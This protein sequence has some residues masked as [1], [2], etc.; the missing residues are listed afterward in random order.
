MSRSPEFTATQVS[1]TYLICLAYEVSDYQVV[2]RPE[3]MDTEYFDVTAHV[4]GNVGLS[5][6]Q[7][8]RPLQEL[9]KERFHLTFRHGTK[10]M[11]GYELVVGAG[12]P[13]LRRSAE[14][15]EHGIGLPGMIRVT[16]APMD[17]VVRGLARQLMVPVKD[18][19]GLKGLYDAILRFD[20]KNKGTARQ[21][22]IFA[23]VEEQLGLK[24]VPAK[25]SVETMMIVHA[26]R[27]PVEN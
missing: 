22:S 18:K 9:L 27:I 14:T 25:V 4:K 2:N 26:G 10:T 11:D 24:L 20:P 12:G 21:P 19:T 6:Q 13:K 17:T 23:A 16:G 3:W 5:Y 15:T 1:L 7:L 8:Q